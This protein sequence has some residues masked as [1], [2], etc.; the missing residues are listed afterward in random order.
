[1]VDNQGCAI[2]LYEP[3]IHALDLMW[4]PHSRLERVGAEENM[5]GQ[6]IFDFLA[7]EAQYNPFFLAK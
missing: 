1:V 5:S 4:L 3:V 2:G 6:F 7:D